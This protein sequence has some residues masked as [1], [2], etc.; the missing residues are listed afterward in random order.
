[1]VLSLAVEE[2][3][4]FRPGTPAELQLR[5]GLA[6]H[7]RRL[8]KLGRETMLG[9]ITRH[10][11][12]RSRYRMSQPEPPVRRFNITPLLRKHHANAPG[13]L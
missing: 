7:Q 8:T 2:V 3:V 9:P 13:G 5:Q 12:G 4:I 6:W 10:K 1:M 11:T